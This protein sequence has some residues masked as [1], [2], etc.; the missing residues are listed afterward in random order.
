MKYLNCFEDFKKKDLVEINKNMAI[1]YKKAMNIM[2][3]DETVKYVI[4]NCREFIERPMLIHRTMGTSKANFFWSEPIK[5]VSRDNPN[6]YTLMMD[7]SKEW[8]GYPERGKSFICTIADFDE[9]LL[10]HEYLVIPKDKSKWAVAPEEDIYSCFHQYL[11]C[12]PEDFFKWLNLFS[13]DLGLNGI[14]DESY[15]KMIK[16]L[17]KLEDFIIQ[18]DIKKEDFEFLVMPYY[19]KNFIKLNGINFLVRNIKKSMEPELNNFKLK[20]Y[21]ELKHSP[22]QSECWTD[23]PCV[24]IKMGERSENYFNFL[25]ALSKKVGKEIKFKK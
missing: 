20:K 5:R 15:S 3:L 1:E 23:S 13:I 2:T 18:N 7:N 11:G 19:I 14:S 12:G 25:S 8:E 9:I 22:F 10:S 4:E 6:W 16:D 24:F 21:T 17:N